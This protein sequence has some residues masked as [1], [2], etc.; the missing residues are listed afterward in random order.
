[1]ETTY[2]AKKRPHGYNVKRLRE[3]LGVKQEDLAERMKLSQQT[4]SR[5]ESSDILE[6]DVLEKIAAALN[7]SPQVIKDF[8]EEGVINIISSTLNAHDNAAI[9]NLYPTFNT[10]DKLVELYERLL[11]TEKQ[12][13]SLLEDVLKEKDNKKG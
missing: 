9:F 1:M 10:V 4:I 2:E 6:D 7:I 5:Y 13:V 11:E 8:N 3:I 12:K